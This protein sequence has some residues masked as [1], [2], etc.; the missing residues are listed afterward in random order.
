[1]IIYWL[2]R[3]I[4]IANRGQLHDDPIVFAA[5]DRA[6]WITGVAVGAILYIAG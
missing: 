2:T 5:R 4:L 1:V 6:S 3:M